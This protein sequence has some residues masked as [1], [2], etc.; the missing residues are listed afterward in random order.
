MKK[1]RWKS[2]VW[3]ITILTLLLP[4][5]A[6]TGM[7][8]ENFPTTGFEDRS[9][10]GY[11]THAEELAFLEAVSQQSERMSYSQ[12]GTTVEGR[13]LH[14]VRIGYPTPPSDTDIAAGRSILIVG[15]QHGNE[16]AGREAALQLLRDLAFTEDPE[17]LD[18]MSE[19]TVLVIPSANPDGR[20][21]NTRGNAWGVDVNRDH[22]NLRTPEGQTIA[23]VL[24]DFTPEITIDAHEGPSAPNNPGQTPRLELS[25]PR[26]LNVDEE[27]RA[28]N[29]E[30]VEDYVF[31]AIAAQGFDTDVYGSPGGAGGG[32]ERISRNVLGLRHGIGMLI[33]TFNATPAAR[34][35]LQ[36]R[37]IHEV[38]K[39]HRER[40]DDVARVVTEAPHRKMAAGGDQSEPFYLGG[41][42]WEP[43]TEED[44]LDVPPCGYVINTVQAERIERLVSL[45]SLETE[46]VSENGVFIT[47][48][49]P[50]MTVV[51]LL[52]DERAAFNEVDGIALYDCSDPGSVEPPTPPEQSDPAQY[53]TDFTEYTFGER[54]DGWSSLWRDSSWTVRDEPTRLEHVVGTD[55]GRRAL[56]W[57]MVGEVHGD[58]EIS[59]VVRAQG[60]RDTMLQI[61]FHMSGDGGSENAYYLDVKHPEASSAPNRVRINR[62]QDGAFTGL[63]SMEL[64]FTVSENTWYRVVLQR[65]GDMIRA[66]MW[67]D[68]EEEPASW[69]IVA[70][71]HS[72]NSGQVG[73]SHFTPGVTNEWAF[74]GV[75]TGGEPAPRAPEDLLPEVDRS[76]LQKRVDEINGEHL[77]ES[78]YTEE[79]WQALQDALAAAE[80]VLN[81]LEATQAEVDDAL[82]AL[83]EAYD[84]LQFPSRQYETDF[85]E[86]AI[87]EPP[88]GWSSLW[89]DSSWTVRDEPSRLEHVVGTSDGRRAFTW[90]DV[91]EVQGDVEISGV[92][93]PRN[94]KE[95]LLQIGFHLSGDAEKENGYYLDV[96]LPD[97]ST[98]PN[99]VRI[100]RYQD[101]SHRS[102]G[103]ANLPFTVEEDIWYHVVLQREKNTLRAKVWRYGED[104]PDEW[105]VTAVDSSFDRGQVGIAH[106]TANT[107]NDWAFIGVGTGGAQAPRAPED[108]FEPSPIDASTIKSQVERFAAEG[109]FESDSA[110]RS[111]TIHLTAVRLYEEQG[112]VE[113]ITKHMEGFKQLLDHQLEHAVI[114]EEAYNVLFALAESLIEKWQ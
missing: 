96:R 112:Q 18:Q 3:I 10:E 15:S 74:I 50:M 16:P 64:P 41:S 106:F 72:F 23:Q 111:L 80:G 44:I 71:D 25:W 90:D 78:D 19:T 88:V 57:D 70:F 98:N 75:G 8:A 56:T 48:N 47:M 103:T 30:M 43:P 42:D 101:G 28:L 84:G 73:V 45:F 27:L 51:P 62:Y 66:K 99:H 5:N 33:E 97:A 69:Q 52:L 102:L 6:L 61:G 24:R 38:L 54:P 31:P 11:T 9:G 114:S 94:V 92:V 104:E 82:A 76:L 55:G 87:G 4:L 79:S 89:R 81:N 107:V 40:G 37:T 110:V 12:V 26:N 95:T 113:K 83:N 67:L 2:I 105:Q 7:A 63:G 58:V 13:P 60:A 59:G 20:E 22:L 109:A 29:V 14:L 91:G 77:N 46:T 1:Y 108:L 65:Q 53:E 36:L 34:V 49:Q 68:G 39:F 93:R 21:A 86:Y 100:N 85:T 35:D 17:L 32:D